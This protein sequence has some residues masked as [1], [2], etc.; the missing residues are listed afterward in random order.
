MKIQ[1]R[2]KDCPSFIEVENAT[3]STTYLCSKHPEHDQ[4]KAIG[5]RRKTQEEISFQ[6]C[7]FDPNLRRS[8]KSLGT[9]HIRR[10]GN[11]TD[12]FS[13]TQEVEL[14]LTNLI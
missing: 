10:Q 3:A 5:R 1:C 2:I 8:V 12:E 13:R 4:N 9:N 7:Q 11:H 6:S 14:L